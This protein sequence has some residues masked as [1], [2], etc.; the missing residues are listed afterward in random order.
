LKTAR[1][2][3]SKLWNFSSI[4][5]IFSYRDCLQ[6]SLSGSCLKT[7]SWSFPHFTE[8]EYLLRYSQKSI[9]CP[10]PEPHKYGEPHLIHLN[11]HD[12]SIL[13]A[14]NWQVCQVASKHLPSTHWSVEQCHSFDS[15]TLLL[16]P[17]C[18]P[19]IVP[20]P[21][22]LFTYSASFKS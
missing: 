4:Y 7:K 15:G 6:N 10:Y 8:P 12:N 3:P 14:S 18:F 16:A 20:H 9:I 5:R 19:I 17:V 2:M 11:K 22:D 1:F 21:H 13:P